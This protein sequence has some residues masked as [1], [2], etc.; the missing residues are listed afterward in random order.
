MSAEI[1]LLGLDIGT[2]IWAAARR[3]G[4]LVMVPV[5]WAGGALSGEFNDQQ[6]VGQIIADAV[7]SM[8]PVAGE[9]TA[10]RDMV[11]ITIRMS[12][13]EK[14][15]EDPMEW[16]KLVLCLLAVIPLIGGVLKGVGKLL[17]FG[18][19]KATDHVKLAEDT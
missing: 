5:N 15:A 13:S 18:G 10:A 12:E 14:H 8:I 1:K 6:T 3:A 7:I 19:Q 2:D 11:A 16:V 4:N 9:A 17:V